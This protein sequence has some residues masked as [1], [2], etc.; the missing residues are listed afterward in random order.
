[1]RVCDKDHIRAELVKSYKQYALGKK[2]I[3][4]TIN[5]AHNEHVCNE[6]KKIG[7]RVV[8]IDGKTPNEKR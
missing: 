4:Y 7:L 6:F 1:M 8:A 2:G 5:C 3:I